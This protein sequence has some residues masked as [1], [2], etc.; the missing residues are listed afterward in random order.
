MLFFRRRRRKPPTHGAVFERWR[1]RSISYCMI[2]RRA[3]S[4]LSLPPSLKPLLFQSS[5]LWNLYYH[6][7]SGFSLC[8][9]FLSPRCMQPAVSEKMTVKEFQ[10]E[11]THT[12][13]YSIHWWECSLF[14]AAITVVRTS[15]CFKCCH[16]LTD[17]EQ[18]VERDGRGK[19]NDDGEEDYF[20]YFIKLP[21]TQLIKKLSVI[22]EGEEGNSVI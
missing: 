21:P 9:S 22:S 10:T 15:G 14:K 1:W 17:S 19:R 18:T 4:S 12:I 2:G 11:P 13:F 20:S 8:G 6:L 3:F 7:T 5:P 16:G